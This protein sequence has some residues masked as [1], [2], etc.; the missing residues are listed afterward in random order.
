MADSFA[1]GAGQLI[2]RPSPSSSL[3]IRCD[4]GWNDVTRQPLQRKIVTLA[5]GSRQERGVML[6]P[7]ML[8]MAIEAAKVFC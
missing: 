8:S 6:F 1:D 7:V 4:V 5:F 3:R 2:V